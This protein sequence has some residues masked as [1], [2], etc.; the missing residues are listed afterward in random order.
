MSAVPYPE[1]FKALVISPENLFWNDKKNKIGSGT[2]G[3]VYKGAIGNDPVAIKE[4]DSIVSGSA[5][6]ERF[7]REITVQATCKHPCIVPLRGFCPAKDHPLLVT[8]F[9][10][11]GSMEGLLNELYLKKRKP[12]G[13]SLTRVACYMYGIATALRHVHALGFVHRDVKPANVLL[14]QP[15]PQPLLCDFGQARSTDA[16]LAMS[17][18]A[19]S[20]LFMAPD[21]INQTKDKDPYTNKVDVYSFGV[22]AYVMVAGV[23]ALPVSNGKLTPAVGENLPGRDKDK[24]ITVIDFQQHIMNGGRFERTPSIDDTWWDLITSCWDSDPKNRPSMEEICARITE[25]PDKFAMT[26]DAK[27]KAQF[28]KYVEDL[29]EKIRKME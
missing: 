24:Q 26:R 21:L 10:S 17:S 15:A 14:G 12:L 19:G 13:W 27:L 1:E 25:Q 3:T 11:G 18:R 7:I 22:T 28:K 4:L 23:V 6:E 2:S 9:I 20:V 8:K 16:V 5:E 29:N